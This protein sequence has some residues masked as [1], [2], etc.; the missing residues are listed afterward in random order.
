MT[1][2]TVFQLQIF[3]LLHLDI[4]CYKQVSPRPQWTLIIATVTKIPLHFCETPIGDGPLLVSILCDVPKIRALMYNWTVHSPTPFPPV[5][6]Q[7][8]TYR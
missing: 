1:A 5:P 7:D 2:Q 3:G 8:L 4:L 6:C